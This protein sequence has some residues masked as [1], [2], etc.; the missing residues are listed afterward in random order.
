MT[1]RPLPM[2]S[3]RFIF[4]LI[5]LIL[6]AASLAC[7]MNRGLL[8]FLVPIRG[9]D[10]IEKE[11]WA[12]DEFGIV[13]DDLVAGDNSESVLEEGGSYGSADD[14][15]AA[16]SPDLAPVPDPITEECGDSGICVSAYPV[17][18]RGTANPPDVIAWANSGEYSTPAGFSVTYTADAGPWYEWMVLKE[19]GDW[20]QATSPEGF[21]AAGVQFWGD[22]TNGWARVTLDGVEIWRGDVTAFGSDGT[23]YFVYIEASGIDPG[24]H[25][26][27]AE[28]L[29]Q[30]GIGGGDNVPVFYFAYRK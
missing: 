16:D 10:E 7:T 28:V 5:P 17:D 26:L 11:N 30:N 9:S 3:R 13:P 15:A 29:G 20:I 27:K 12:Y 14:S 23:N 24:G 6:A 8:N 21:S 25:I 1:P 2:R 19:P 22:Q 18:I 4:F